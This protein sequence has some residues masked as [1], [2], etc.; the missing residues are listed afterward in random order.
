MLSIIS[1]AVV[2]GAGGAGLWYFT[3]RGGKT[4]PLADAPLLDSLIPI[5]IV[6]ALAIGVALV[7]SGAVSF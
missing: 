5:G 7:V 3:P 1:G 4:H 6:T 2:F